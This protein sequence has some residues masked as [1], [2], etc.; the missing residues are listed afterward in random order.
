MIFVPWI[1]VIVFA[2]I[3][4]PII[5]SRTSRRRKP[6]GFIASMFEAQAR[7]ERKNSSHRGVMSSSSRVG[8]RGGRRRRK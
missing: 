8:A 7:T 3:F 4:A 6:K 5:P 1:L 2:I